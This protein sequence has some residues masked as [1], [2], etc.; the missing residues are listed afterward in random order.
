MARDAVEISDSGSDINASSK[1]KSMK[2]K[3]SVEA[4]AKD[5]HSEVEDTEE[6]EGEEEEEYE[7]EGIVDSQRSGKVREPCYAADVRDDYGA[8]SSHIWSGQVQILG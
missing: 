8:N 1:S 4:P 2:G 5:D 3:K 7:I 6:G